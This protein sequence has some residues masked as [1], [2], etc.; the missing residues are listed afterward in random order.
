MQ[1]YY[2]N[3]PTVDLLN[4][5][6]QN[7]FF[8]WFYID[9]TSGTDGPDNNDFFIDSNTEDRPFFVH[10]IY[11]E[12]EGITSPG[13]IHLV[14]NLVYKF[15]KDFKIPFKKVLRA[16]L[17]LSLSQNG[18]NDNNYCIPHVDYV[19]PHKVLLFYLNDSDGDTVMFN[20]TYPNKFDK[21]TE[22]KRISPMQ[23]RVLNFDGF[24]WHANYNPVKSKFRIVLNVDYE[25]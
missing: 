2:Y 3:D 5:V 24:Q 1:V 23:Y 11:G 13:T 14:K 18:F 19:K 20:E 22:H 7:K 10:F 9:K 25:E 8:H 12:E 15:T 6:I 4:N 16:K 21:L 17:N